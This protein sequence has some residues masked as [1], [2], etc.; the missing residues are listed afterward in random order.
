MLTEDKNNFGILKICI[1]YSL[2]LDKWTFREVISHCDTGNSRL[3]DFSMRISVWF[4]QGV[5]YSDIIGQLTF[6]G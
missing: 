3:S 4:I 1:F 5:V 2:L 6:I